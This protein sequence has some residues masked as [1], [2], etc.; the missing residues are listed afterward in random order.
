ESAPEQADFRLLTVDTGGGFPEPMPMPRAFS[1]SYSSDSRRVAYDEI[2]LAFTPDWYEA[3]MWRH[4]RGGRTHPITVMNLADHSIEKLPW[5]NS[6]D[7]LPMWVGNT[8]YFL[9]D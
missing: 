9:S 7:S 8:I 1:A 2:T 4:Y 6:N 5:T 3:S